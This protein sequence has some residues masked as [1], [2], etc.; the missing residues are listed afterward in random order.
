LIDR[1]EEGDMEWE[2]YDIVSKKDGRTY[3]FSSNGPKGLIQKAVRFQPVQEY[4]SNTFNLLLGDYDPETDQIDANVIG[5]NGDT[6]AV[7]RTVAEVVELFVNLNPWAIILIMSTSASRLRLYRMG[8]AS[9]WE[10]ISA[11]YD[12]LGKKNDK[13]EPF[14]KGVNYEA[15]I[16]VKKIA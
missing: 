12:I 13:V 6:K 1:R 10:E 2:R 9:T 3:E 11:K 16:V 7:L 15:F 4:G 5:D 8:I 14:K